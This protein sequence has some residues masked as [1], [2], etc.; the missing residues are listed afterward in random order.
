MLV[1]I[2]AHAAS[3]KAV[4]AS[5]LLW[6]FWHAFPSRILYMEKSIGFKSGEEGGHFFLSQNEDKLFLLQFWMTLP[7]WCSVLLKDVWSTPK[8][9]LDPWQHLILWKVQVN[10]SSDLQSCWSGENRWFLACACH[11]CP[12]HDACGLLLPEDHLMMVRHIIDV[13]HQTQLFCTLWAA[14]MLKNFS[15]LQMIS[16]HCGSQTRR[17]MMWDLVSLWPLASSD[18]NWRRCFLKGLRPR[19]NLR[20]HR[21][22]LSLTW[23][24]FVMLLGFFLGFLSILFLTLWT[25]AGVWIDL[26]WPLQWQSSVPSVSSKH[27]LVHQTNIHS[28]FR[29]LMMSFSLFPAISSSI[30]AM[31]L[32]FMSILASMLMLF[33]KGHRQNNLRGKS[34]K[35]KW[36]GV[37]K[38]KNTSSKC[39]LNICNRN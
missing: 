5:T 37:I 7:V 19:S 10:S 8:G 38:K 30:N 35:F 39:H 31:R 26:F 6:G 13:F 29:S 15:S 14:S 32:D 11:S 21:M 36:K 9:V 24:S 25:N 16:G 23:S 12:D 20:V 34:R 28:T 18:K 27:F 4:R 3:M 22:V 17:R 1:S 2:E 33:C